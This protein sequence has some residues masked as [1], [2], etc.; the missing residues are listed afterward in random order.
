M[1]SP[2]KAIYTLQREA[3]ASSIDPLKP[4]AWNP[5]R[6]STKGHHLIPEYFVWQKA[7]TESGQQF[8]DI[9]AAKEAQR[10]QSGNGIFLWGVGNNLNL[11]PLIETLGITRPE[12]IFTLVNDTHPDDARQDLIRV[13]K[14]AY[15]KDANGVEREWTMPYGSEVRSKVNAERHYALVCH[16]NAPLVAVDPK[17]ATDA[18][19]YADVYSLSAIDPTKHL[20]PSPR[21]LFAVRY[22][23]LHGGLS[24]N[25]CVLRAELVPPYIVRLDAPVEYFYNEEDKSYCP[26]M[27]R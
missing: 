15:A 4:P 6:A 1:A 9:V 25:K 23:P 12:V 27:V 24:K 7:G 26:R 20:N 17:D 22:D 5:H 14:K 2:Q 3:T 10:Q 18:F 8:A 21:T 13:W 19:D 11:A 16:S